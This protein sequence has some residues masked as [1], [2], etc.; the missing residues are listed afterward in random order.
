MSATLSAAIKQQAHVD[1]IARAI[2]D[3][4]LRTISGQS[5]TRALEYRPHIAKASKRK[6]GELVVG[7]LRLFDSAANDVDGLRAVH[8]HI[9]GEARLTDVA[10]RNAA[11]VYGECLLVLD[12]EINTWCKRHGLPDEK[13]KPLVL[14]KPAPIDATEERVEAAKLAAYR[15]AERLMEISEAS[16]VSEAQ[17]ALINRLYDALEP[18]AGGTQTLGVFVSTTKLAEMFQMDR[19]TVVAWLERKRVP[20]RKNGRNNRILISDLE[21]QAPAEWRTALK[22][23]QQ[24]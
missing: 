15:L 21:I 9:A 22:Q 20:I 3:H 14:V 7:C 19:K 8:S 2:V 16:T 11:A 1:P 24:G 6:Q 17:V 23:Y 10:K 12:A 5:V 13:P 4:C 18:Q